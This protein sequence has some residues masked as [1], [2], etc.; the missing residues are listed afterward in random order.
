MEAALPA[1]GTCGLPGAP[2]ARKTVT[3]TSTAQVAFIIM[4]SAESTGGFVFVL[5]NVIVAA[6]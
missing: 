1:D 5:D 2:R 3:A 6:Q 4:D